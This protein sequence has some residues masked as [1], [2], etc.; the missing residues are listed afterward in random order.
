MKGITNY[1]MDESCHLLHND[2]RYMVIGAVACPKKRSANISHKI[3]CL[4]LKF[5]LSADFEI[6]STKIS[7]AKFDFYKA[8][9]DL[10]LS[11]NDLHFRAIIIDKEK[12]DHQRFSQTHDDFYYKM[13]YTLFRYFLWGNVNYIY[14]D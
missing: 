7:P 11:E 1:F 8:V 14:V 13:V 5:G 9:I 6:K 12:L 3:K 10:F 4:K 2:S